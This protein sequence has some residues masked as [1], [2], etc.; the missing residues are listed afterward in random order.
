MIRILLL[1]LALS[2]CAAHSQPTPADF[3][4]MKPLNPAM[5]DYTGNEIFPVPGQ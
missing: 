3:T 5:W 1:C 2:A 4:S